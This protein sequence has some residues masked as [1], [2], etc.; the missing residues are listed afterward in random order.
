MIA[1]TWAGRVHVRLSRRSFWWSD[2]MIR[3]LESQLVLKIGLA[4]KLLLVDGPSPE[5]SKV[6]SCGLAFIFCHSVAVIKHRSAC[7]VLANWVEVVAI[8][9]FFFSFCVFFVCLS[10]VDRALELLGG[11]SS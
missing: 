6:A 9:L 7:T 3:R 1:S 5:C 10:W 8:F 4:Y 2:C 11:G